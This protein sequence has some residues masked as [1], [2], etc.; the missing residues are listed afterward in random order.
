[1]KF[2]NFDVK[3]AQILFLLCVLIATCSSSCTFGGAKKMGEKKEVKEE[4]PKN[5]IPL[6]G[7]TLVNLGLKPEMIKEKLQV[8]SD[9]QV[10]GVHT[11]KG[12]NSAIIDNKGTLIKTIPGDHNDTLLVVP[13]QK[14]VVLGTYRDP[15]V[16]LVTQVAFAEEATIQNKKFLL[17]AMDPQKD[18]KLV[19]E[20]N[21]GS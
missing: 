16:G 21:T 19:I 18:F 8:W 9:G 4:E 6:N 20:G 3:L 7:D 12:T 5:L 13:I 2:S 15:K 17:Y 1:M 14:G 11:T 10:F